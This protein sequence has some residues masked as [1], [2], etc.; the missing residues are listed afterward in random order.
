VFLPKRAVLKVTTTVRSA[1]FWPWHRPQIVL[2]LVYCPVDNTLLEVSSEI[3]YLNLSNR[4]CRYGN[5]AA[6]SKPVYKLCIISI[7]N[8]R[9]SLSTKIISKCCELVKSCYINGSGPVFW[10]TVYS[11]FLSCTVW[12]RVRLKCLDLTTLELRRLHLDLIFC[13]KIVFGMVAINFSDIFEFSHVSKTRG[14]A[15][16]LFKSHSNNSTRYRFFAERVVSVWNS[17]PASVNFSTLG[18][19]KRSITDV[20][21]INFLKYA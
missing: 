19:F 18:S 20:D 15:Y 5:H 14:H 6:G 9:R 16:K 10:D 2:L 7:E 3:R 17:L 11:D 8:W 13:Y 4:Y 21:F 1:V 12:K